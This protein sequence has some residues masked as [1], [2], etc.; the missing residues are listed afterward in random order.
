MKKLFSFFMLITALLFITACGT[1]DVDQN[2]GSGGDSNVETPNEDQN[3]EVQVNSEMISSELNVVDGHYTFT[4]KNISEEDITLSFS[5][6]QEYEYQIKDES[7]NLIYTYSM[8]KMF[9]E[10]FM[11]KTLAPNEEYTISV[12]INS[13]LSTLD[14]GTYNLEIWSVAL[15]ADELKTTAQINIDASAQNVLGTYVGGI[16]N[17]SVEIIGENNEPNAYRLTEAADFLE[18]IEP[19]SKVTF[20]YYEVDGQR[21]LTEITPQ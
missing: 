18:L 7:G 16:D 14:P 17:S 2:T 21:F 10:M 15:E 12:D 13:Y 1:A 3:D 19:N 9:G 4:L 6:T 5:S 20:S 11:E 8:D